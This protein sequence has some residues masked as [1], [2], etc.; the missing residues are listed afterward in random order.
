MLRDYQVSKSYC[1]K[2][3]IKNCFWEA[4]QFCI[5]VLNLKTMSKTKMQVSK[6]I[7]C[8]VMTK[9]VL[10]MGKAQYS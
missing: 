2:K 5:R 7:Y 8:V 1:Y 10:E 6:K 9:E 3:V 4:L